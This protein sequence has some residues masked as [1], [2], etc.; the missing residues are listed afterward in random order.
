MSEIV[1]TETDK[2][3]SHIASMGHGRTQADRKFTLFASRDKVAL[4]TSSLVV[5]VPLGRDND[6]GYKQPLT[7]KRYYYWRSHYSFGLRRNSAGNI[8]PYQ[9]QRPWDSTY[10]TPWKHQQARAP[11][12]LLSV[13]GE[14]GFSE[15]LAHEYRRA[16]WSAF[17]VTS[18]EDI[19]P[20]L[21]VVGLQHYHTIPHTLHGAFRADDWTEFTARAFGKSRVTARLVAAVKGAEPYH[22]AYARNFRGLVETEKMVSYLERNARF[23]EE[24]EEKFRPHTPDFRKG[25]LA[26]NCDTRNAL[27]DVDLTLDD[28]KR[29]QNITSVQKNYME[30]SFQRSWRNNVP[31]SWKEINA[32]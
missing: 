22:I 27:I 20:M 30:R 8:V 6:L 7:D 13:D 31:M 24:M 21:P 26:A 1:Y 11:F 17:D 18:I 29:I 12:T 16:V 3:R 15:R 25:V 2:M 14:D 19:F 9:C 10:K 4:V 32:W 23:D 28:M 5:G